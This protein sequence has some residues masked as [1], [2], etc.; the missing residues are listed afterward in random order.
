MSHTSASSLFRCLPVATLTLVLVLSLAAVAQAHRVK[1]FA[2]SDFETIFTESN[3]S[4]SSPA[5]GAEITAMD[6]QGKVV[7]TGKT[8]DQGKCDFAIPKDAQGDL[9]ITVNAGEGHEGS[10]VLTEAEY[11]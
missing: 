10:W 4:K 1:I 9:T 7:F 3:F 5:M 2:Y 6:A 11:R 8:D